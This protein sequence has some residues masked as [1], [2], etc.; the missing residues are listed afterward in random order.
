M[1][2]LFLATCYLVLTAA[3]AAAQ[4]ADQNVVSVTFSIDGEQLTCPDLAVDLSLAGHHVVPKQTVDGFLVPAL[5]NRKASAWPADE[6]VD[7]A[8][9]C[10]QNAVKFSGLSPTWI[11]AGTW[12]VGIAYPTYWIERFREDPDLEHGTWMTYLVFACKD[13]DPGVVITVTQAEPPTSVVDR[14]RNEQ[15]G[16]VGKRARD[17]AYALAAFH[18]EYERNRDYLLTSLDKCLARSKDSPEDDICNGSLVDFLS[19]LYWRGDN[20]ILHPMTQGAASRQE[21]LSQLGNFYAELLDR[22]PSVALEVLR[23]LSVENQKSICRSAGEED[24]SVDTV[25]FSRVAERLGT[26]HDEVAA[27]CLQQAEEASVLRP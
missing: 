5:F 8:I 1:K 9:R 21:S 11:S 4:K 19:N 2:T 18:V 3:S 7:A 23:T 14:L 17:I 10:G 22:R 16:A 15:A 20:D 6:K 24:F 27:R 12:E 13:C 25:R 26:T